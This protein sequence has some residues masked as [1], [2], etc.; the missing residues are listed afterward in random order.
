MEFFLYIFIF[1]QSNAFPWIAALLRDLEDNTEYVNSWCSAVLVSVW[2]TKEMT[3]EP[4]T[5]LQKDCWPS[6]HH[7]YTYTLWYVKEHYHT[8][9]Q[10]VCRNSSPLPV[11]REQGGGTAFSLVACWPV[12]QLIRV[13]QSQLNSWN[14]SVHFKSFASF[15][16]LLLGDA[17]Q[18][19]LHHAWGPQQGEYEGAK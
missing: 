7:T 8:D 4:K 6:P 19:L 13:K 10:P 16:N 2:P 17:C 18:H 12:L 5:H 14:L 11:W 3:T 1:S 9:W 15:C